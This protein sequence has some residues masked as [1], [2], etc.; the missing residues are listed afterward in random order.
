MKLNATKFYSVTVDIK[1]CGS[2]DVPGQ[3]LARVASFGLFEAQKKIWPFLK[4]G[5][6]LKFEEFIK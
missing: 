3:I 5:W 6:P 4:I 2:W 1:D